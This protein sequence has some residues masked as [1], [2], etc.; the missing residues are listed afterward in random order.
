M[1]VIQTGLI[2]KEIMKQ[3]IM[4]IPKT[5]KITFTLIVRNGFQDTNVGIK[6]YFNPC[7]NSLHV[8]IY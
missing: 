8:K 2:E 7:L 1:R 3:F 4:T 5:R 6:Y